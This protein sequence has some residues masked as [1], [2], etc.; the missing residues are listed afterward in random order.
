MDVKLG[1][2]REE[3]VGGWRR[4]HNGELLNFYDLPD[5]IR[6]IKSRRMRRAEHIAHMGEM[7]MYTFWSENQQE[8]NH[9][10]DL[11]IDGMIILECISW[12]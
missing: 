6:V 5:I 10:E 2:K 7:R 11:D 9:S 4:L 8:R 1:P 3:M 12:K